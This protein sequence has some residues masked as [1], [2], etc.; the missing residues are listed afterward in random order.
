MTLF[1]FSAVHLDRNSRHDRMSKRVFQILKEGAPSRDL[2]CALDYVI[3]PGSSQNSSSSIVQWL[4]NHDDLTDHQQENRQKMLR[5]YRA[6]L[7]EYPMDHDQRQ[8]CIERLR[9]YRT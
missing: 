9:P 6:H 4:G 5:R 7:E 3:S 2:S 1:K 8:Y